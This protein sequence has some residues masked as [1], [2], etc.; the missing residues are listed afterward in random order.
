[1]VKF[2]SRVHN[3]GPISYSIREREM[4]FAIPGQVFRA[5]NV[6]SLT[7]LF[8]DILVFNSTAA[9]SGFP[10]TIYVNVDSLDMSIEYALSR[11]LIERI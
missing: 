7:E 9:C 1:M 10:Q 5:P 6:H 8:R 3:P 2:I 11:N 4:W